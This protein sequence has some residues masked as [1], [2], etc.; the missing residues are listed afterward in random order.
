METIQIEKNGIVHVILEARMR[1]ALN[2]GVRQTFQEVLK[3]NTR[4]LLLNLSS[5]DYINSSDLRVILKA[6]KQ[7]HRKS[8]KVVLCCLKGYLKEV[9]E[10][11]CRK[12]MIAVSDSVESG[13]KALLGEL[14]A[15]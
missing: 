7:I 3:G 10:I 12:D 5:L 14:K 11:T 8:G 9:F 6:V 15:A 13:R 4:R 1:G 2:S